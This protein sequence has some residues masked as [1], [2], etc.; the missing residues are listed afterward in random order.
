[1]IIAI[2]RSHN[3]L[4]ALSG[5]IT[6]GT[7]FSVLLPSSSE[8]VS[9]IFSL[10]YS[11]LFTNSGSWIDSSSSDISFSSLSSEFDL[12]ISSSLF[13]SPSL[14]FSLDL[15]KLLFSFSSSSLKLFFDKEF[16]LRKLIAFFNSI[17]GLFELCLLRLL[18]ILLLLLALKLNLFYIVQDYSVVGLIF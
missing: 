6:H 11:F 9:H 12:L 17:I 10:L 3:L 16:V 1:M 18:V 15:S 7:S 5:R 4:Y 2:T 8:S 14:R 13:S